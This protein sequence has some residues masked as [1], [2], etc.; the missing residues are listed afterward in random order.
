MARQSISL[1]ARELRSL[2]RRGEFTAPTTG[3]A[4]GYVQANLVI[5]PQAVAHDFE[6]FCLWNP[7]PCPLIEVTAPGSFNPGKTAPGA[8]LRTD[9]PLYRVYRR[10]E[11]IDRPK[12]LLA[13]WPL[14]EV[15][16]NDTLPLSGFPVCF[17]I[18]CS[19][20]FET[21]MLAAELPVRHIEE[22]RNV[23]MYR[24]NI[25]CASAGLFHG[26][27]VVSMRPM[28]SQQAE[29]A[30][31]VTA[32]FPD[33]HGPP[34]HIGDPRAI[35]IPDLTRPDYGDAVTMRPGEIAVFW[36]CG[37]TPMEAII[38]AKPDWAV[39]HDP[40]H[41]FVTDLTTPDVPPV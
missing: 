28:T 4:P 1:T 39:T 6:E 20:T 24:T 8:D 22:G 3:V 2:V 23:P 41:M 5:L 15:P 19:F 29:Q 37:V 26:P 30:A 9:L 32:R 18:G 14:I 10:G 21:A 36:A 25:E 33:S 31:R 40:G 13:Y 11:L 34:V 12:N 7:R 16:P 35:G 27:M 17:L 38:R